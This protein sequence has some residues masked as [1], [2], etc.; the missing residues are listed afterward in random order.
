MIQ[1]TFLLIFLLI[2]LL[3]HAELKWENKTIEHEA[4]P[5]ETEFKAAFDFT[6][7]G[8]TPVTITNIRSTCGCTTASL[9]KNTYAPGESGTITATFTYGA[10]KGGQSKLITVSTDQK[11]QP[12]TTL[13]LNVFIPEV[14]KIDG[15]PVI[16]WKH[17]RG[18]ALDTRSIHIFSDYEDPIDIVDI[19][20]SNPQT[21]D[22][23]L[24]AQ[25]SP[26]TYE[27][28]ITPKADIKNT[29]GERQILRGKFTL[30]SNFPTAGRG[31]VTVYALIK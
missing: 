31:T 5:T 7:T 19:I 27:L 2:P 18:E 20:N 9:D 22:Y 29:I 23:E 12:N 16:V 6:N 24:K 14:F 21:F 17:H 28:L 25:E 13:T 3:S 1:R 8:D 4:L 30:K 11:Q 15:S 26:N 10:R